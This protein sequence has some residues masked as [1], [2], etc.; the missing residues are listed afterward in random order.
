MLRT[1]PLVVLAVA[2][3]FIA[4][5]PASGAAAETAAVCGPFATVNQWAMDEPPGAATM[6]D[7]VGASNGK[8]SFAATGVSEPNHPGFGTFYRFGRGSAFPKGAQVSV[9]TAAGL[10]PGSCD[11]AVD[12]WVNWNTVAPQNKA[13]YNVAQ[14]GLATASANW[15]M[16]VDGRPDGGAPGGHFGRVICVFDGAD[17]RSEVRVTS[18]VGAKVQPGQWTALHCERQGDRFIVGV[19]GSQASLTVPGIG[20][21]TNSSALTVGAKKLNDSDT[22]PGG[23]DDLV[24]SR[25]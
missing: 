6:V 3:C 13:T 1:R 17:T 7:A 14:K 2:V 15:K 11:F 16:E 8:V 22:F 9:P 19:D 23:V 5:L 4:L 21:I 24:F 20:P 10:N 18:P 25:G 12:V